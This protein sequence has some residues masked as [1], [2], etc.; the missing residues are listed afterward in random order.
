MSF[1]DNL[2]NDLK[3]LESREERDPAAMARSQTVQRSARAQAL[4]AA[5][6][7]EKLKHG[8]FTAEL[9]RHATRIAYTLRTKVNIIWLGTTLRLQAREHRLELRPTPEG[10]MARYFEGTTEMGEEAVDLSGNPEALAQAWLS[11]VGPRPPEPIVE[12]E[13]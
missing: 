6:H 10:V 7:A 5:P 3:N 1:S 12:F 2:E 8:T 11:K 9:L 4:A 13:E